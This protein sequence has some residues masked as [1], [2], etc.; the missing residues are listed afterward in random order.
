MNILILTQKGIGEDKAI[1]YLLRKHSIKEINIVDLVR[2]GK[3]SDSIPKRRLFKNAKENSLISF[4]TMALALIEQMI[5]QAGKGVL[6]KISNE[7]LKNSITFAVL[8][9]KYNL[10]FDYIISLKPHSDM[11]SGYCPQFKLWPSEYFNLEKYKIINKNHLNNELEITVEIKNLAN[12][13]SANLLEISIGKKGA[14]FGHDLEQ[15]FSGIQ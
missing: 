3:S 14:I 7:F 10:K 13:L 12:A 8:L 11:L 5:K 9:E 2:G 6:I 15:V 4:N 1:S